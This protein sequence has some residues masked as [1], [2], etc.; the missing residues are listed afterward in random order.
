MI[1]AM[2]VSAPNPDPRSA[3]I[4]T[5]RAGGVTLVL[6]A[7][8]SIEAGVPNWRGLAVRVWRQALRAPGASSP[9]ADLDIERA[10]QDPQLLPIIF[11]L[12]EEQLG[13]Q[14]FVEVLRSCIYET[15][16]SKSTLG[17]TSTLDVIAEIV[18]RDYLLGARRRIV[19]IVTFN[20]DELLREALRPHRRTRDLGQFWRTI[21]HA[22]ADIAVGRGEQ[23]VSV[24]HVHG[25]LPRQGAFGADLSKHRLVFTDSQYWQSGTAQASLANRTMNAALADSHCIFI[26]LSMTD[27][28]LLRWLALRHNEITTDAE[29]RLAVLDAMRGTEEKAPAS[30][31]ESAA[32]R[33][34]RRDY[35]ECRLAGH[36]WIRAPGDDRTGLLSAFLRLR[37][38]AAVEIG[39]WGDGSLAVLLAECF[40]DTP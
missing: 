27:A 36:F 16:Q 13:P 31:R 35:V 4:T 2:P 30:E 12:A 28:N 14:A 23:P 26:G 39:G 34:R 21:D 10:V 8:V 18:T 15:A 29:Y 5:A 38:V 37:G 6:G 33:E 9:V 24:Y 3:L 7:G 40:P 1:R 22:V 20:A 11:E 19:R 32:D 25:L 17:G